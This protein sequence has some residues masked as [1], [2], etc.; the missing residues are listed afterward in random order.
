VPEIFRL[1]LNLPPFVSFVVEAFLLALLFSAQELTI[2]I[3]EKERN[4]SMVVTGELIRLMNY[5][6]DISATLRRMQAGLPGIT[7]DERKKL[8]NYMRDADPNYMA[9]MNG[10]DRG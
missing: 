7:E 2:M 8:A 4:K 1:V 9:I 6:D 10:L 5:V 3:R